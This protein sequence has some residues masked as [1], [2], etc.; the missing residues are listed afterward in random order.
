MD[1]YCVTFRIAEQIVG[2]K[3]ASERR[4]KLIDNV[5]EGSNG[6]WSEPTSFMIAGS[7]LK[8]HEFAKKAC[9]GISVSHDL[10]FIFDPTDMSAAYFGKI[11]SLGVLKSFFPNAK[12]VE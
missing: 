9:E 3:S 11:E 12:K 8:T 6:F 1:N 4:Q 5:Y 2:D 7:N 10:V